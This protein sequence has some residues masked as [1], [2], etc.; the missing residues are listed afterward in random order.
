MAALLV[1]SSVSLKACLIGGRFGSVD[2]TEQKPPF[3]VT[4]QPAAQVGVGGRLVVQDRVGEPRALLRHRRQ[5]G[6]LADEGVGVGEP[7][8][9]V[10]PGSEGV[11]AEES[12]SC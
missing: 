2:Y 12:S 3:V 5:G 4:A 11:L 9:V 1:V 10:V 8:V 7:P 6:V